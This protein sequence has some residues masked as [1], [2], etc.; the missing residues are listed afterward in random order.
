VQ[1]DPYDIEKDRGPDPNVV[2]HRIVANATWDI[3]VGRGRQHGANMESWANALFGG[4]TASSLFQA[5]SG[6][7]LTPFFSGFYTTSPWNT[8]K[9]LDGL[10][11][12]FCCAW[13]PDQTRDPKAGGSR[14]AFFDQTA[15]AI[16]ATGQLGNARKGSLTGP[17][18]WV[19]N[20]AF[21]KDVV[22]RDRFR[23]QF[24]ALLDN[25]FNHPQ[26]FPTY[27]SDFVDLSSFLIDDDPKNGTTGVLG[28]GAIGNAE[29][30]SPGRVM[31]LGIRAT[32]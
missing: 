32:F 29:G 8:G 9:P 21:Y 11:N 17:G 16:S 19:V 25:A 6:Q 13:R 12:H 14:D 7:H 24:S 27:G 26:F 1:F 30:F 4:G 18:T 15:Y 28:A 3:P 2:K 5:R 23:L 10:G 31:R 22:A 20:F